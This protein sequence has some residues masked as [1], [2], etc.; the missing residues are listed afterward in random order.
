MGD[1]FTHDTT[2]AL[3]HSCQLSVSQQPSSFG[4]DQ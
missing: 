2:D 4:Y 3:T 1:A